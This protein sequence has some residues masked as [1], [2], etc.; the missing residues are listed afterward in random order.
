MPYRPRSQAPGAGVT[1]ILGPTNTGKTYM[2]IE[3][4]MTHETGVIGLPLRLLAR[5][6]YLK[7]CARAGQE[8]VALITGEEKIIPLSPRYWVSTVEAMPRDLDVD[9]V[10]V[11]E[12]QMAANLE[13]GHV[14]TDRILNVRGKL[15]TM[16]LGAGTIR[17]LISQLLPGVTII[18][19]PRMS[20][21]TYAGSKKI[22]R[23]PRRTAV[24]AFSANDVYAIAE[25][26]RRQ[27]GGAAVVLGALSPRTRNAQVDMYQNGDVDFLVATDAIGM[28]LNL[29]VDHVAFAG[30]HKFDGYD[31][32][33]LTAAEMGQISGRAGR[34][35]RD[36][37]FGVTSRTEPLDEY[38][39]EK[40]ETHLFEPVKRLQW[41]NA[42]L[43]FRSIEALRDSLD[44]IPNHPLLT[45]ALPQEDADTLD[46]VLRDKA[47]KERAAGEAQ[48]RLLWDTCQLPDY[49]KIAPAQHVEIVGQLFAHLVDQGTVA[50]DWM[51]AQLKSC[52]KMDG[53][54]D[55]LSAR[56]AQVRTWTFVA[57][58]NDW[59]DD[60]LHWQERARALEDQLSDRLHEKLTQ[61]FVDRRTSVLMRRLREKVM[62]D[63]MIAS[64]GDVQ[65]EGQHVGW[66]AGFR[67]TP[68]TTA[69]DL[70]A[71]AVRAAAQKALAAEIQ[72]RAEKLSL[73]EDSA[74]ILDADGAI[75]WTGEVVAK[76]SSSDDI[77]KPNVVLLAD[78]HL[79]GG[80]RDVVDTRLAKWLNDTVEKHL[81]PLLAL[82]SGDG[83]DGIARGIGF[84]LAEALG[85][86][87]RQPVAN[88]VK[89][90]DQD[91]R[92]T[93]RKHGVRFGAYALFVPQLLKPA[94]V[95]LL[96]T[97]WALM[98]GGTDQPGL[99]ELPQLNAS[100]RTSIA[101]DETFDARLYPICGFRVCGRRAVRFDILERLA[102]LI[103]PLIA[104]RVG[105]SVGDAPEGAAEGTGFTVTV[106]M[107]SLL[108]CAGDDF[109]EV[110]KSLGYR[111]ERKTVPVEPK[112]SEP[113]AVESTA[114]VETPAAETEETPSEVAAEAPVESS[115]SENANAQATEPSATD[116]GPEADEP[117]EAADTTAVEASAE[118]AKTTAE[119]PT[120]QI[121][122][123]WRPGGNRQRPQ[124]RQ[125]R[126]QHQGRDKPEDRSDRPRSGK[127]HAKSK[128]KRD[129]RNSGK[130]RGPKPPK[131]YTSGPPPKERKAD[132]DSPFA[133][134]AEMFDPQ[135]K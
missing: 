96:A 49:R 105:Q 125:G 38:L 56:I 10:C 134:L 2:A 11:D 52:D 1:A 29:D 85:A 45:R 42:A 75:R 22:T 17:G 115:A 129:D 117:K 21:I 82:R 62:L 116:T 79:T 108:G 5:E 33:P 76:L 23:Q 12:V 119:E 65:V 91:A 128:A 103:R 13:R 124:N 122:E 60:P 97:L 89:S 74:F 70:D 94:P 31:Y 19:R 83:L 7:L 84:Q 133:A 72:R 104:F 101:I 26:I 57:N 123:I 86:V 27:R 87:D 18:Q 93:L 37:T 6:V 78:E 88:D 126:H 63:A 47:M 30:R 111:V 107:T 81:G 102:D 100:G 90:L 99:R 131:S 43:D 39:V 36:G 59:L 120:E 34:H 66:L 4:M 135:K 41:R 40:L 118:A 15:E 95:G 73:A 9:F 55:A 20:L 53:D 3:R 24:V 132:P 14:F 44:D 8:H 110:L 121:I 50:N 64:N 92:A 127:P 16:L 80:A 71:K 61:R 58:R 68:D 130:G 106:E 54:I 114:D 32:R 46:T 28:G 77:L 109:S 35:T 51:D 98:H 25:L 69:E 67:F 48:V 113:A 112:P